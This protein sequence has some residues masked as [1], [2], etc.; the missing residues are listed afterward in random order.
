MKRPTVKALTEVYTLVRVAFDRRTPLRVTAIVILSAVYVLL[1]VDVLSDV[2]PVI[3]WSDDLLLALLGRHA[4]YRLVPESIVEDHRTVARSQ[5]VVA[6]VV[7]LAVG[8]LFALIV[9]RSLGVL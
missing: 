1:P 9:A 6:V 2:I 4:V 5:L 7:T 3:G 8:V